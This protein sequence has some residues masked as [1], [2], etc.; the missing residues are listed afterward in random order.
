[1]SYPFR[2][3]SLRPD[4]SLVANPLAIA[5]ICQQIFHSGL[6]ERG[7]QALGLERVSPFLRQKPEEISD[8][9]LEMW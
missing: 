2:E 9:G 6:P 1:M 3:G 4:Y 8:P 5:A 7:K